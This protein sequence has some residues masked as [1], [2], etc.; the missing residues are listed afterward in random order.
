MTMANLPR[1]T[2]M[3]RLTLAVTAAAALTAGLASTALASTAAPPARAV[4]QAANGTPQMTA[5][6]NKAE[7]VSFNNRLF[8]LIDLSVISK[9]VSSTYIQHNP[10][11]PNGPGALRALVQ[12][13][14]KA[15]PH[16]HSTVVQAVAQ[17]DLVLLRNHVV[18]V[19]GTKGSATFDVYRLQHG[20]IV[21]HWDTLQAIPGSTA[22]GNSMLSRLSSPSSDMVASPGVTARD[23]GIV[24]TYF[25]ELTQTHDLAA[26]SRYVAPSLY[27]H[28]P[29]LKD[30]A[31]ALRQAYA[32]LFAR[33]P[34]FNASVAQVVAEGDLVAV[35]VHVQDAPP[36]LGQSVFYLYRVQ[37]GKITEE[38][39]STQ[40]VP[41]TSAN[42]N[43]MF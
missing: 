34:E 37:H 13:A 36:D 25:T 27:Q 2:R 12:Q 22:S 18:F 9:D 19:P 8:N 41:A 39:T 29:T 7:I 28:D 43:T 26:I 14:H 31:A 24:L 4:A 11:V 20:K 23:A 38:W 42:D 32:A 35:H 40:D 16:L 1:R 6:A 3:T 10:T 17:G 15:Y 5:A 33:A 30:G 21:E